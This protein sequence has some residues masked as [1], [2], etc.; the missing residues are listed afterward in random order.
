MEGGC[1]CGTVRYR[2]ASTPY[3]A[4]WCHCRICQLNSGA[5][6]MAF[7][8]VP[9]GDFLFTRNGK[10]VKSFASSPFGQRMF[11]GEC[12]T[13]LGVTVDHQPDTI[14]FSIATLDNPDAVPPG[15]HIFYASKVV[16]FDPGDDLPRHARFRPDTVGPEG[17]EPPA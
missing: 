2:L 5:P 16:W 9:R 6:A 14:D 15:F 7:A 13:P 10:L 12:G 4:G 11:C 1:A 17:A 8:T 3:D